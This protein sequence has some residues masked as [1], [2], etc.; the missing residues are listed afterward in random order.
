MAAAASSGG[1]AAASI[2]MAPDART[3]DRMAMR[4]VLAMTSCSSF[5]GL[6]IRV[7]VKSRIFAECGDRGLAEQGRHNRDRAVSQMLKIEKERLAAV[8]QVNSNAHGR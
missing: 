3:A 8:A 2:A 7:G 1:A 4:Q 5:I 6:A